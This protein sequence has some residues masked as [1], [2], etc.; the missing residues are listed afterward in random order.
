LPANANATWTAP[1]NVSLPGDESKGV[2]VGIDGGGRAF[3]VWEVFD[4]TRPRCCAVVQLRIRSPGGALG[5]VEDVSPRGESNPFPQLAL[6]ANGDAA[7]G[8]AG[9]KG[10]IRLSGGSL[11]PIRRIAGPIAASEYDV[12]IDP[13]ANATFIW[14]YQDVSTIGC[15]SGYAHC[16]RLRTRVLSPGGTLGTIATLT[17]SGFH[18][19]SPHVAVDRVGDAIFVWTRPTAAGDTSCFS[20]NEPRSGGSCVVQTRVRSANGALSAPQ[21]LSGPGATQPQVA[22]DSNGNA[23]FVWTRPPTQSTADYQIETRTR[24]ASGV[25]GPVQ[26]LSAPGDAAFAPQ[27]AVNR[28]G[29]AAFVWLRYDGPR[30]DCGGGTPSAPSRCFRVQAR[31]RS[32]AGALSAVQML[33]SSKSVSEY[34]RVGIDDNAKAV[35]VWRSRNLRAIRARTRS[36]AGVL[37]PTQTI[38]DPAKPS[39]VLT[40]PTGGGNPL[41]LAVN[42]AGTAVA[43]WT[44]FDGLNHR[45]SGAVGP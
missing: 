4:N 8:W 30:G 7:F 45:T 27:V 36:S 20:F 24:S 10:R 38:S 2:H 22:L 3:F 41:A 39:A 9:L 5:P 18:A 43:D 13:N 25:L 34:P 31:T 26:T 6:N 37:S 14:R 19:D 16:L 35:F 15:D 33:S 40:G 21:T 29:G 32:A 23:T 17:P 1:F 44:S 28:Y 42:P 11:G 12:G